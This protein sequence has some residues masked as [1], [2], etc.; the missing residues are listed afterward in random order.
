MCG[1]GSVLLGRV[2]R[3]Y[4]L[5]LWFSGRRDKPTEHVDLW[6]VEGVVAVAEEISRQNIKLSRQILIKVSGDN[7]GF[8]ASVRS[9]NNLDEKWE[10]SGSDAAG[11]LR[12]LLARVAGPCLVRARLVRGGVLWLE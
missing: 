8:W 2:G 9:E 11:W 1:A 5:R 12:G 10:Q 6:G 7:I 4:F 3:V